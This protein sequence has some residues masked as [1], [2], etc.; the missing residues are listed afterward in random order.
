[1]GG[2]SASGCVCIGSDDCSHG[3]GGGGGGVD[4]DDDGSGSGSG[5]D[6]CG[7]VANGGGGVDVSSAAACRYTNRTGH[8]KSNGGGRCTP[9]SAVHLHTKRGCFDSALCEEALE[10]RRQEPHPVVNRTDGVLVASKLSFGQL[11]LEERALVDHRST[12][13]GDGLGKSG[14]VRWSVRVDGG[15]V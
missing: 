9:V 7:G 12:T 14:R 8:D 6:G 3:C 15:D 13:L 10:D 1:M 5:D 4:G 11:V 2:C